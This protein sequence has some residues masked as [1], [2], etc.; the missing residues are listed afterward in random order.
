M[1]DC[2]HFHFFS[3]ETHEYKLNIRFSAEENKAI[4]F[5]LVGFSKHR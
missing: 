1:S 4:E 3:F 2:P 5:L